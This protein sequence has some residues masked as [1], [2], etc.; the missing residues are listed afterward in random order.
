MKNNSSDVVVVICNY[1]NK[2]YLDNAIGTIK[3]SNYDG[4]DIVVVDNASTD[5]SSSFLTNQHPDVHLISLAENLGGAGGFHVGLKYAKKNKYPFVVLMDNDAAVDVNT[6]Y[7]MKAYLSKN[8]AVGLVGPAICKM[9]NSD[10]IQEVG[11]LISKAS[12]C[13]E[14]LYPGFKYDYI[15]NMKP[16]RSDYLAACCV[17]TRLDVLDRIGFFDASYFIYWDDVDWCNRILKYGYSIYALPYLRCFHKCGASHDAVSTLP[18]Y[19]YWRNRLKYFSDCLSSHD[20]NLFYKFIKKDIKKNVIFSHFAGMRELNNTMFM[21]INDFLD[22]NF[23]KIN[24]IHNVPIRVNNKIDYIKRNLPSGGYNLKF[25][26]SLI[27]VANESPYVLRDF[28]LR[29]VGGVLN[30]LR[31]LPQTYSFNIN[32]PIIN[33]N[34]VHDSLG[35]L[36]SN[37][38]VNYGCGDFKNTIYMCAHLYDCDNENVNQF[39]CDVYFNFKSE[40]DYSSIMSLMKDYERMEYFFSRLN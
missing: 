17:M 12:Y 26:D 15:K 4:V 35:D 18:R 32:C 38:F 28:Y 21:A 5:G 40:L 27:E 8:S 29:L 23:G 31:S 6:I 1:N 30:T 22:G 16:I 9:D 3:N 33:N 11:S 36:P 10:Y 14:P 37:V 25:D 39:F 19:Y 7:E 24:E 2:N 34:D 13:H 20:K